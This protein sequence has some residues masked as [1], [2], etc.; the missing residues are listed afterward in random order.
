M[1]FATNYITK[2][3]IMKRIATFILFLAAI[4]GSVFAQEAQPA[5]SISY[6][7]GRTQG[8]M[9]NRRLQAMPQAD[10][11]FREG[12]VKGLAAVLNV[13]ST[14]VGYTDGLQMG[15]AMLGDLRKFRQLGTSVDTR[16]IYEQLR[17]G[18]LAPSTDDKAIA[19]DNQRLAALL[20]PM[21]Q[22][23]QQLEE[24]Q[25]ARQQHAIDSATTVNLD[26][27]DRFMDS[28][29]R[30]DP[31]VKFL[32]SGLA[33]KVITKGKGPHPKGDQTV[34]VIYTG[35]LT[36]G[37][38]F[39]SSKGEAVSFPLN[40]VIPGF[41]QGLELMNKGAHYILYIP[42]KLAY[43]PRGA[44][45]KIGPMQMLIFDVELTEIKK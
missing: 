7:L 20:Q 12:L 41:T 18:I 10:S 38:V 42:G 1:T 34:D 44:G 39:D 33:Y 21:M 30:N 13:D 26:A 32:D 14:D 36:D 24:A 3:P 35:S 8:A 25:R 2:Q 40:G 43:G 5:D 15:L 23:A 19:A 28:L 22:R 11:R 45:E 4:A 6:Y 17:K 16:E 29:R 37:T 9:I 31:S 27:A